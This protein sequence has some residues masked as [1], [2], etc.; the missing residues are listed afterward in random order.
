[1]REHLT[2]MAFSANITQLEHEIIPDPN[3]KYS[4]RWKKSSLS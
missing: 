3:P 2:S 4:K 1:M